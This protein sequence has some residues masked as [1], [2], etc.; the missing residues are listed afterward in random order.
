MSFDI[1]SLF[2][3]IQQYL[4]DYKE[5]R[6]K[7]ELERVTSQLSAITPHIAASWKLLTVPVNTVTRP[8]MLEV[9]ANL[10]K[11][12]DSSANRA[13]THEAKS[14]KVCCFEVDRELLQKISY[15]LFLSLDSLGTGNVSENQFAWRNQ[16][17]IET[18]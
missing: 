4:D 11:W 7:E 6:V 16:D 15:H 9:V 5:D 10:K 14:R 18:V 8:N 12:L 13:A 2:R 1:P 3:C 17:P